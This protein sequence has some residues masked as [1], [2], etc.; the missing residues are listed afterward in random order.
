MCHRRPYIY[1]LSTSFLKLTKGQKPQEHKTISEIRHFLGVYT[2]LE[3]V[4][5]LDLLITTKSYTHLLQ[6][7]ATSS[8]K[9]IELND[10]NSN[11]PHRSNCCHSFW[12]KMNKRIALVLVDDCLFGNH[13]TSPILIYDKTKNEHLVY[14]V[15]IRFFSLNF[16]HTMYQ[17]LILH[18]YWNKITRCTDL[19]TPK[20]NNK[21]AHDSYI[22]VCL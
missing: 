15:K 2:K 20:L 3:K 22:P 10:I 7:I 5:R 9:T 14:R 19:K 12:K 17:N 18:H 21:R 13:S 4:L 11:D 1:S 16:Y 8:T 6:T